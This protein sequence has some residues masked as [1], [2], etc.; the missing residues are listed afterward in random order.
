MELNS[1]HRVN[2]PSSPSMDGVARG[3]LSA[4]AR[5]A[6]AESRETE[7]V[8]SANVANETPTTQSVSFADSSPIKGRAGGSLPRLR[9][10]QRSEPLPIQKVRRLRARGAPAHASGRD[11]DFADQCAA[12]GADFEIRR[13]LFA[14]DK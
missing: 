1:A 3:D 12:V 7:W 5:R 14:A 11:R 13:H 8:A 2:E 6:K 10:H 9:L 4:V